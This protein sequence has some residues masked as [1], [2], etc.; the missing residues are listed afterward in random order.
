L[1]WKFEFENVHLTAILTNE[2]LALD[3]Q[4]T[5]F[6]VTEP[7]YLAEDWFRV[8]TGSG[9]SQAA[10][11]SVST[12]RLKCSFGLYQLRTGGLRTMGK[13]GCVIFFKM[14]H[15]LSPLDRDMDYHNVHAKV[16]G[17]PHTLHSSVNHGSKWTLND[18]LAHIPLYWINCYHAENNSKL[19][20]LRI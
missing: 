14:E 6:I 8:L 20:C 2:W 1:V 12:I 10:A 15:A 3:R 4:D 9:P 18:A 5:Q 13:C 19:Q 11:E 17:K 16:N 7:L